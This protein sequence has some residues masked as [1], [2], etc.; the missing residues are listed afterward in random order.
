MQ[1]VHCHFLFIILSIQCKLATQMPQNGLRLAEFNVVT[2]LKNKSNPILKISQMVYH[3][4]GKG[5]RM[6]PGPDVILVIPLNFKI[7]LTFSKIILKSL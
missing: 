7:D 2:F 4:L 1:L 5:I 3:F 6:R